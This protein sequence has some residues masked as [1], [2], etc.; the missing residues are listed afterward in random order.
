MIRFSSEK[1][2]SEKFE[3]DEKIYIFIFQCNGICCS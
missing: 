3:K 1:K 2:I